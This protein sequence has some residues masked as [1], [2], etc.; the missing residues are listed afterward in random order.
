MDDYILELEH[1]FGLA[2]IRACTASQPEVP[3]ILHDNWNHISVAPGLCELFNN[4]LFRIV[5]IH[6]NHDTL[7]SILLS[8][9]Y[10]YK[11]FQCNLST[12]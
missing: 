12:V 8:N 2:R 11:L 9:C 10:S 5:T 3:Q 1:L 4:E 6:F 7:L